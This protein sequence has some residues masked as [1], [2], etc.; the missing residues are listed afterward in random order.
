[1][2]SIREII[3]TFPYEEL[4][5]DNRNFCTECGRITESKED[6]KSCKICG[7]KREKET[8]LEKVMEKEGMDNFGKEYPNNPQI[9]ELLSDRWDEFLDTN[10]AIE[11]VM[12]AFGVSE[13]DAK[14]V[15]AAVAEELGQIK[16]VEK[17]VY[18]SKKTEKR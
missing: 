1:M 9:I 16:P 6:G 18:A 2:S 14:N 3:D 15:V 10:D 17:E 5:K 4:R 12:K 11:Q 13:E 8:L 7:S